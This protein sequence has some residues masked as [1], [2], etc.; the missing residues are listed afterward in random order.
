MSEKPHASLENSQRFRLDNQ[1]S[2][3][4]LRK[5]YL[6]NLEFERH[7][8]PYA[9]ADQADGEEYARSSHPESDSG[10]F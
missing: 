2:S 10:G 8:D 6:E 1:S 3:R 9:K 5:S 7:I 4:S